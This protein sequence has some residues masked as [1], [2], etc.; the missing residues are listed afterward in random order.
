MKTYTFGV[1]PPYDDFWDAFEDT[2][3]S[4]YYRIRNDHRVGDTDFTPRELYAEL[5]SAVR[6]FEN[7][8]DEAGSWASAVLSTLGFE[9]V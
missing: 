7:G 6:D 1:L 4:M 8:D 5:R 3:G 9:W 2:V